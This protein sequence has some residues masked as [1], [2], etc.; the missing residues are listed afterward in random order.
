MKNKVFLVRTCAS[1]NWRE[2]LTPLLQIA[3]FNPV[4]E[5]WTDDCRSKEIEQ[6]NKHCGV[7]L[8]HITSDM[9]GVFSVAEVVESTLSPRFADVKVVFSVDFKGFCEK[10]KRSLTAVMEMVA[11]YGA[12]TIVFTTF[13]NLANDINNT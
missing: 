4:V 7:H 9:K 6:K 12:K 1:T 11:G 13:E 2:S 10:Q 8:Y 5:D 3:Y